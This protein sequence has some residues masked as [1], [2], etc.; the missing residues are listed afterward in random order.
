MENELHAAFRDGQ[1]LLHYQPQTD[2][3]GRLIGAEALIRWRHP[4]RGMIPPSEFIPAAESTGARL[5][6]L[7]LELTESVLAEDLETLVDK[8]K[9]LKAR[10]VRFALDDFGTGYS[11]LSYLKRLPLDQLK[12]DQSFVRDLLSDLNDEVIVKTILAL[13]ASFG[14]KVIAE[15]V[16]TPEQWERLILLGCERHQGYLFGRRGPADNLT[17]ELPRGRQTAI[18]GMDLRDHHTGPSDAG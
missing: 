4:D 13:G 7:E 14:I 16:E 17:A 15:G 9:A 8:M 6:H 1:P 10:G 12:I 11:S 2:N 18:G 3:A 5:E